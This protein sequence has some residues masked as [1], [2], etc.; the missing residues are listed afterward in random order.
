MPNRPPTSTVLPGCQRVAF[1]RVHRLDRVDQ[2]A[3]QDRTTPKL[4]LFCLNPVCRAATYQLC[5]PHRKT[6]MQN[7]KTLCAGLALA[8]ISQSPAAAFCGFF[9]GKADAN[10]FNEASQVVMVRD[11]K[12]TV[13]SLQNDYNGPLKEFAL[14]VPTPTT[15]EKGQVRIADRLT[16]ERLDAYSSPRLAE[17]HDADPCRVRFDWGQEVLHKQGRD[18]FLARA[19]AAAPSAAKE[20]E[21]ALGVTVEARYTLGEYDIVSLSATQSDGLET[22]LRQNG[23]TIPRGASA[24]LQPYINQGMKVLRRQS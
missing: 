15:L 6:L 5:H 17:Y 23:Y 3:Y 14:I 10:L 12:R 20:R 1:N 16:F 4:I 19:S 21:N 9:A 18:E 13:L 2:A 11:G 8:A 7:L 22:W 24:A